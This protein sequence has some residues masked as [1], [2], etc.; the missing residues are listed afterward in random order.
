MADV[1]KVYVGKSGAWAHF[2]RCGFGVGMYEAKVYGADGGLIDKVRCDTY[3]M[4]MD[5]WR[6]FKAIA[7]NA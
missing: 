6:S 5:Y 7:K 3:R 1:T 4:A 2:S